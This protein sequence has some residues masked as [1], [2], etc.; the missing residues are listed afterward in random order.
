MTV[1][2]VDHAAVG[3]AKMLPVTAWKN[4]L[5]FRLRSRLRWSPAFRPPRP[6]TFEADQGRLPRQARARAAEL[7]AAFPQLASWSRLLTFPE[8][9]EALYVL[10]WVQGRPRPAAVRRALDVGSK[11]G[12]HLPA[13]HAVLPVPWTMVELDA[14][15]R[16]GTGHTRAAR[17]A[18]LLAAYTDCRF[19]AA[20]I[21]D[22]GAAERFD[23]ITWSLPFVF[24]EP[25]RRWGLPARFFR[26]EAL[27]AHVLSLLS[28]DGVLHIANQGEA[29]RDEQLRLLRG[30]GARVSHV[31]PLPSTLSPFQR[32]R[33]SIS[34]RR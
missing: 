27:L 22:V 28:P 18:A 4:E 23:V 8:W 14:H 15:R 21:T 24:L 10:D 7:A 25:L 1:R 12:I 5:G 13:L 29:E 11:N 26:P 30:E 31:E 33:W 2:D 9:H 34:A 3:H 19:L 17:A 16:Y 32:V 6:R 20:S